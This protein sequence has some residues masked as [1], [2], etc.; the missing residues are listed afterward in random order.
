[1]TTSRFRVEMVGFQPP[2]DPAGA[3]GGFSNSVSRSTLYVLSGIANGQGDEEFGAVV[4]YSGTLAANGTATID[5]KTAL[6]RFGIAFAAVDVKAGF[7]RNTLEDPTHTG[8]LGFGPDP[9]GNGWDSFVGCTGATDKGRNRLPG[10]AG[11]AFWCFDGLGF[12]VDNTHKVVKL[13][14]IGGAQSVDIEMQL[15]VTR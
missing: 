3:L 15:W 9:A 5:L 14:E 12:V 7:V 1:M 4:S 11:M 2:P 6:D 10:G 8:V 13:S